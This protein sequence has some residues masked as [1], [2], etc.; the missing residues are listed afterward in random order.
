MSIVEF[1]KNEEWSEEVFIKNA[2]SI[3]NPNYVGIM[4]EV[5]ELISNSKD[6]NS[7]E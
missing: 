6:G 4:A 1:A 5:T 2:D 3:P 7:N